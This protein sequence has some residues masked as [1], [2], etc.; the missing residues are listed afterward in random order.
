MEDHILITGHRNPDTDSICSAIAYAEYKN[1]TG[2]N[3]IPTRLGELNMETK[4][5]L[6]FF[7]VEVPALLHTVKTQVSD[8]MMDTAHSISPT[9]S[10]KTAWSIMRK[11]N[12]KTLP[13]V[14]EN[15]R[16]LGIATLSDIT[17]RLMDA[18]D[19]NKLATSKTP[20]MNIVDTLNAKL[21][22]G[23]QEIF[24]TS[25]KIVI[26]AVNP[27][28]MD[29]YIEK[30]D[31]VIAGNRKETAMKAIELGANCLIM[32]CGA[33]VDDELL[34]AAKANDCV[35][36]VTQ[37]DTFT[38]ARLVNQSVPVGYMM[39]VNNIVKF[40]PEDFIEEI[41]D[42]MLATRYRS[43][44]VVDSRNHVTGLISRF[45]LI[46]PMR[47]KVILVDHNEKSQTVRGI[48]EAEILE[49]IDH[50]KLGDIQTS[51]PIFFKNE[52][53]GCTSTIVAE[54]F[55]D[56]GIM[57]SKKT[58]GIMCA[59]I[60]SDTLNF[61]S[62]TSTYTDRMMAEKLAETANINI[63]EFAVKMFKAGS[64]LQGKTPEQI[65]NMDFKEFKS[66]KYTIGISQ[67]YTMDFHIHQEEI[68]PQLVEYMEKFCSF[69]NLSLLLLL[70]TDVMG[71]G[72]E[73]LFTGDE[74]D[75]VAKA[76]NVEIDGNSVFL[77]EVVSRKKQIIPALSVILE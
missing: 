57:P 77:P 55:F 31:I 72:S 74:T 27:D 51:T 29:A 13:I 30:S 63:D 43:Y 42:K 41:K 5:V 15:N 69:H 46:S 52:P 35:L 23:S 68:Y 32:T 65:I 18:L 48:E 25:G 33:K 28:E 44:P 8:L 67:V 62:P 14:D 3:A 19:N 38:T 53:V 75:F 22:H 45:H 20:L 50:H 26:T 71:S 1:R 24:V 54:M 47:K 61:R 40:D 59:A 36:M 21:L 73:L 17:N 60:I 66:G 56:S 76:F 39:T 16:F 2:I 64:T 11:N 58:A 34:A 10:I 6:N 4:F 49:I 7:G 70:V 9:I 12:V 37:S